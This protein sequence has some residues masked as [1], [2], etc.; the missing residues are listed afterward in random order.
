MGDHFVY[1]YENIEA[2]QKLTSRALLDSSVSNPSADRAV[3]VVVDI[4]DL[5]PGSSSMFHDTPVRYQ[6][7]MYALDVESG[8][9]LFH[10]NYAESVEWKRKCDFSCHPWPAAV[11]AKYDAINRVN[12]R[13]IADL[14]SVEAKGGAVSDEG[15]IHGTLGNVYVDFA[16]NFAVGNWRYKHREGGY[17]Q[18]YMFD[19]LVK[20]QTGVTVSLLHGKYFS[21]HKDT[22][23]DVRIT[24]SDMDDYGGG[25]FSRG[26]SGYCG[27]ATIIKNGREVGTVELKESDLPDP[28][29]IDA[30]NKVFFDKITAYF[31]GL[32]S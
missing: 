3:T 5:F 29:T 26:E 1:G 32:R 9:V 10:K 24:I 14:Y 12:D 25:I 6:A 20:L 23:Y 22:T 31:D 7:E 8:D 11:Q 2:V 13:F 21:H 30:N 18:D 17:F 28:L 15:R 19:V 4:V 27:T 16:D